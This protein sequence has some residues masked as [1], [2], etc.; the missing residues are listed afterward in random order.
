MEKNFINYY[1]EP[2]QVDEAN[3]L[4]KGRFASNLFR[5]LVGSAKRR[6]K[7]SDYDDTVEISPKGYANLFQKLTTEYNSKGKDKRKFFIKDL[8]QG[9][10]NE[11]DAHDTFG[12][13]DKIESTSVYKLNNGGN[14]LLYN[15]KDDEGDD[16]YYAAVD[17]KGQKFFAADRKKGGLGMVFKAWLAAQKTQDVFDLSDVA[18]GEQQSKTKKSKKIEIDKNDYATLAPSPKKMKSSGVDFSKLLQLASV[19]WTNF[20]SF[21]ESILTEVKKGRKVFQDD[22][23]DWKT[24][25]GKHRIYSPKKTDIAVDKEGNPDPDAQAEYDDWIRKDQSDDDLN[26]TDKKDDKPEAFL[27]KE[28]K[29]EET[30]KKSDKSTGIGELSLELVGQ[31]KQEPNPLKSSDKVKSGW[32][33]ILKNNGVIFIYQGK[34]NKY[35]IGFDKKAESTVDKLSLVDKYAIAQE[36]PE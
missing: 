17:G 25:K 21:K 31:L 20:K 35:Y 11:K 7:P 30:K 2:T 4:T 14:I 33:Y 36:S 26:N 19:D 18:K 32:R 23:D 8:F 34:D 12:E 16:R 28:D 1:F 5:Q 29:P 24:Y 27:D 10:F 9:K 3:I 15:L 22:D 6:I 13:Y